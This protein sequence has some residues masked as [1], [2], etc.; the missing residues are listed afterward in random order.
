MGTSVVG[1][2]TGQADIR[3]P[4][5]SQVQYVNKDGAITLS[6]IVATPDLALMAVMDNAKANLIPMVL[7]SAGTAV[8]FRILKSVLRR[9]LSNVQRNLINPFLGKG[10]VRLS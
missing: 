9:P 5:N 3:P 2:F 8:S 6:E 1:L 7:A 10:V 4:M